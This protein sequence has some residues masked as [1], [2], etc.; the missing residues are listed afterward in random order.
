LNNVLDLEDVVINGEIA[1]DDAVVAT[2]KDGKVVLNKVETMTGAVE[3]FGDD[4]SVV[5]G[6]NAYYAWTGNTELRSNTLFDYY[7]ADK[8]A[9]SANTEY[10]VY[11]NV[12]IDMEADGSVALDLDYAVITNSYYDAEFDE[13]YVVLTFA[14]NSTGTYKVGKLHLEVPADLKDEAND[15]PRD[16]AKNNYFGKIVQCKILDNLTVDLSEQ[17]LKHNDSVEYYFNG[18]NYVPTYTN[19][20]FN[21]K[22]NVSRTASLAVFDGKVE[23]SQTITTNPGT[24]QEVK[25]S[26]AESYFGYSDDTVVFLLYGDPQ[27]TTDGVMDYINLEPKDVKAKAYKLENLVEIHSKEIDKLW[28][29]GTTAAG[30]ATQPVSSILFNSKTDVNK[31]VVAAA[32]TVGEKLPT[33]GFKVTDSLGYVVSAYQNY[34]S[35]TNKYFAKFTIINEDGL[36]TY[37]T[38]EGVQNNATG[39]ALDKNDEVGYISDKDGS[40]P[41]GTFIRFLLN[42]DKMIETLDNTDLGFDD[43]KN[44]Y[45]P[46]DNTAFVL[47]NVTGRNDD[48]L[49]FHNSYTTDTVLND[50]VPSRSC[51]FH[52]DGYDIIAVD[53]GNYGGDHLTVLPGNTPVLE[54]NCGNAIIQIEE[55]KIVRVFSFSDGY[56]KYTGR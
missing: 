16:F 52:E 43:I 12:I 37:T 25:I 15:R 34:N 38:V 1:I 28:V 46:S 35:A 40:F 3:S 8:S 24:L 6:G 26:T 5:I 41:A 7:K 18:R 20:V 19:G 44:T 39:D 2:N 48:V 55:H 23:L 29:G 13:A 22:P 51:A 14:N 11:N 45:N 17:Y 42:G 9:L 54:A 49:F 31:S 50:S 30:Y 21:T 27:F 33:A 56:K 4:G 36:Q 32:M 53:S 47:V 10:Y